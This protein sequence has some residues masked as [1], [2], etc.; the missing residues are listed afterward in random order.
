[1]ITCTI[2]GDPVDSDEPGEVVIEYWNLTPEY[3]EEYGFCSE[4]APN[5]GE[6][7]AVKQRIK[8][9]LDPTG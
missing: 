2:C 5:K 1:M 7:D 4:H 6:L 8:Q 9:G 3:K